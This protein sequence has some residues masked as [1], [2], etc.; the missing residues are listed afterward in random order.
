MSFFPAVI[1]ENFHLNAQGIILAE[2]CSQLNFAVYRVVVFD[3]AAH[4]TNNDD[5][6]SCRRLGCERGWRGNCWADLRR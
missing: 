4:E 5:R 6:P 1:F 3:E 2:T